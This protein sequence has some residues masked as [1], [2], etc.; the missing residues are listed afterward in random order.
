MML[1]VCHCGEY[2]FAVDSRHV[3]ELLPRVNL[4]PL[5][6]A[7]TWFAG[8]LIHRGSALPVIDLKQ[9]AEGKNCPRSLSSRIAVLQTDLRG[10]R[11][12]FGILA[13][14]VGLREVRGGVEQAFAPADGPALF[15]EL[16]LDE[17]GVFQLLDIARLVSEERQAVLFPARRDCSDFRA[18]QFVAPNAQQGRENGTVPFSGRQV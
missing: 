12:R 7:P 16:R 4:H 10:S 11:R 14:R 1:I 8:V 3:S 5:G 6:G 9:L 2:R 13:E 17:Q 15:G 18:D